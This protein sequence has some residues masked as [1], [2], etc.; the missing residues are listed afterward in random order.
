[1]ARPSFVASVDDDQRK[2]GRQATN[3]GDDA[4]GRIWL[5]YAGLE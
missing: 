1:M 5:R 4:L 2:S 3:D